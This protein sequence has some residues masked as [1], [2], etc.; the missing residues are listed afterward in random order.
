MKN[1]LIKVDKENV[2][3]AWREATPY[4]EQALCQTP[5]YTLL[6]VYH[7]AKNG[8]ITLWMFYNNEKKKAFGTA[9]TEIIEHPQKR[10]LSVFLM[11]ADNFEE[12]EVM[13]PEFLGYARQMGVSNIECAGRFGI[14]RLY[15]KLGFKKSYIVMNYDVN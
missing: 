1:K 2:D 9:A 8:A 3:L 11:S 5:E 13:F 7:L 4:I 6:D 14:E 10:I 12:V 15:A